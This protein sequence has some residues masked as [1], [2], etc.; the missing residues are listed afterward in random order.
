[1]KNQWE[2]LEN[3][4]SLTTLGLVEVNGVIGKDQWT[5]LRINGESLRTWELLENNGRYWE[6]VIGNWGSMWSQ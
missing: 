1:M 4:C 5:S 6:E 2:S 3:H